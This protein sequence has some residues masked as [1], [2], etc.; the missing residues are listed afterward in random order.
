MNIVEKTLDKIIEK[1]EDGFD[2]IRKLAKTKLWL[3]SILGTLYFIMV[4]VGVLAGMVLTV[5]AILA[6]ALGILLFC[7]EI[8]SFIGFLCA[9]LGFGMF[10]GSLFCIVFIIVT[11][12]MKKDLKHE[13][14]FDE[15]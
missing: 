6:S 10:F 8:I 1:I 7:V 13:N 2:W 4:I 15:D 9:W 5:A 14:F 12:F 3:A 11:L